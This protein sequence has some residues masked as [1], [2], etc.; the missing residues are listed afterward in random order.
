MQRRALHGI[1]L[2]A[3]VLGVVALS[4]APARAAEDAPAAAAAPAA[5]TPPKL[6][7]FVE[8]APPASMGDRTEAEVVLTIDVDEKGNVAKAEVARS[9]GGEGGE[10][11]DAA[12][13][14][15]A[16]QF[17]FAPGEA[18]GKPVPVRITYS[19]KFVMKPPE[20]P[21]PPLVAAAPV[22]PTAPFSGLVRRRGDR[23][24]LAGVTAVVTI[25]PGDDREAATD[26]AGR[27]AFPALPVGTHPFA[28]R[29][30]GVTPV[31]GTITLHEGKSLEV[32]TFVDEKERFASTV[33]GRRAVLESVEHTLAAE[34]IKKVPGTQGD[35]LKAVQNLPGVARAPFGL[36]LLPV[37]G[38]APQD[39]R[40]YVDGVNIPL[41]YHFGG[42]RSTF[43]SEMV[44]QLTFV[45]G[46]YQAEH[47][48]GLGGLVDVE[49]RKPRADGLHGYAQ[50]DLVDGSLMLEG[51]LTKTLSFAVA[52]RRSWIDATL[53]H[54][55]PNALQLTP[56]YY[57][58]QARLTWR[59]TARD[60][61]D[62]LFFGSD[63]RLQ[64]VANVKNAALAAAVDSH[65]YFHRGVL[66]WSHRFARG[67]TFTS[68]T[69][70]GYDVPFGVGLAFGTVPSKL[71]QHA[72]SYAE[73]AVARVPVG[74]A[75][76]LDGGVDF[77]GQRFAMDRVGAPTAV[78]DPAS[79]AGGATTGA[80]A[81]FRGQVAGFASDQMTLYEN[82]VAP[83]VTATVTTWNKRLTITPQFRLQVLTFSGYPGTPESFSHAYVSP[84]PRLSVRF[85][86]TARVALKA[87]VGLYSQPPDPGSFSRVF[88]NPALVPQRGTQYLLGTDVQVTPTLHV[89]AE[90]FYKDLRHLAV[91]GEGPTDPLMVSDGIGRAYGGEVLVRQELARNFFG[92]VSY[93]L[94]RSQRKDH[95]DEPWHAFQFDQTHIL[96]I[97]ASRILPRGFQ[98]GGRFRYVTGT[99][100]TPVLGSFYD[101]TIDRYTAIS[102][103]PF[104]GRLP[105]F[106]QL[107]VRVDKLFTFD[108][109]RFSMYLDVQNIYNAK[110]PEALSYNYDYRISHPVTGLP[111]LPI[112]GLRG[113]F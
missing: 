41:L 70:V 102:G 112:L 87:A 1:F 36:G 55:T 21:P 4:A 76:R 84:E 53:P 81:A 90:G 82:N 46:A 15:A 14:A 74:A 89:E 93:T 108:K 58:Y 98:L 44:Q 65:T 88:G 9:A 91:A 113:D 97:V 28:L 69:S 40:V 5:F 103:T 16:K 96:T 3:A 66:A 6:L 19:Y 38:S 7:H 37:W 43:N 64:L 30:P 23:A 79:A 60:D 42:L 11:L 33:R 34:E 31:D 75:L 24:P 45:P 104:S 47:G 92:W 8:A 100:N 48:L 111:I 101:A 63:D 72:F 10:A 22:G 86:L 77:E 39:T 107:D 105:A 110:N 80:G 83:F 50:A 73:R 52:G 51:P 35:T 27:F 61:F 59:P 109:W 18:D 13:L 94:S 95:P 62:L 71:D 17:V 25:A 57:D 32:T 49:T 56:I 2:A 78:F 68:T 106:N 99:P 85:A 67:G 54:F 12:A 29:G 26:E 20:P